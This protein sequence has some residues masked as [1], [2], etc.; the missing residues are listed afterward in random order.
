MKVKVIN[1]TWD[2]YRE[3]LEIQIDGKKVFGVSDGEP[4]DSN[5]MRDF[6]DC[7][8]VIGMMQ[9]AWLAGK[10]GEPFDVEEVTEGEDDG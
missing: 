10:L 6:G 3:S 8:N 4:E 2:D 9:M 7:Y 1:E 5:L